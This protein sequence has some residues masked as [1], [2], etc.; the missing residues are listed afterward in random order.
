MLRRGTI[1]F[2]VTGL[3]VI[4]PVGSAEGALVGHPRCLAFALLRG[5]TGRLWA[6]ERRADRDTC[7]LGTR[8]RS[9]LKAAPLWPEQG[10]QDWAHRRAP[11]AW[12]CRGPGGR[13]G[14]LH[15][16]A[17]Q[18]VP[19]LR[20]L[21]GRL[22]SVCVEAECQPTNQPINWEFPG[23]PAGRT[24]R[25]HCG[26]PGCAPC[27]ESEVPTSCAPR[28]RGLAESTLNRPTG[29]SPVPL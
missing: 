15:L 3:F 25:F 17:P 18:R 6:E 22:L 5:P 1:F 13:E 29:S 16:P 26:G 28:P 10:V 8:V 4:I 12:P 20:R 9:W 11:G 7:S 14:R 23:G 27:P 24:W 2:P 21:P 19:A